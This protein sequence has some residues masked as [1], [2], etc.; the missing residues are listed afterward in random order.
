MQYAGF[1]KRF[2]AIFIDSILLGIVNGIVG[3]VISHQIITT[4][5][6]IVVGAGYFIYLESSEKQ[7]TL[8]K[9]VMKIKVVSLE[10]NRIGPET[11]AIR[12]LG[13]I[14]SSAILLIGYFM[15]GFTEKKQ[16]LH[17]II[18]KTLVVN[19]E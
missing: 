14:L 10:G 6:V 18:A 16:A 12:Y 8:G 19:A 4:I 3:S 13:R 5:V 15:A 2:V 9:M 1:W 17:D 11:A 7:A